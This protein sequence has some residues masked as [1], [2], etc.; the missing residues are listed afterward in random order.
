[1]LYAGDRFEASPGWSRRSRG[2]IV[3]VDRYIGSNLAHQVALSKPEKRAEFLRWI[4]HLEYP[5]T[6]A[7][8]NMILYRACPPA[9]RR[10]CGAKTEPSTHPRSHDILEKTCASGRRGGDV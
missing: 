1:M 6:A 7:A 3:L 8:G 2:E 10:N 4:E 5:S 9:G